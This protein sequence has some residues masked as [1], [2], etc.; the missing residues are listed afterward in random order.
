MHLTAP[1][2]PAAAPL[3]KRSRGA[4]WLAVPAASGIVLGL[5]WWLLAPGGLNLVSGNPELADPNNPASW[6]PRDL[7]LGALMLV[8][9][10]A[11]GLTLDGKLQGTD[12]TRRLTFALIGGAAGAAIAWLVGL[13]AAQ[14]WGPAPDPALGAGY[15]FTLRSFAVLVLW[16]GATAF[17]TFIL[18]LFGVLSKKPVK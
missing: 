16:P 3:S 17:V 8:S 14:W 11:T 13:L 4:L 6:L 2:E 7:V 9:G 10:C 18:A 15:G 5:L 1:A 12:A